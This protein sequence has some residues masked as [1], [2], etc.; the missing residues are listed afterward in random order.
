MFAFLL[1]S[2]EVIEYQYKY[3][4]DFVVKSGIANLMLRAKRFA[5]YK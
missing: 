4:D 1:V 2:S 5:E 3:I